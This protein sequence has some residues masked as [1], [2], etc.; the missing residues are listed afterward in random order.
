MPKSKY[1][2]QLDTSVEIPAVRDNITEIGSDVINSLRSA[3]IQ[4]E[5]TLGINPQGSVGNTLANRISAALD[6]QGNIKSEALEQANVLSGPIIDNDIA[7]SAAIQESKLDL[8]FPTQLLQDEIAV[9]SQQLDII[10]DSLIEISALLTA[11]LNTSALNRH[12]ATA[13]SVEAADTSPS[14]TASLSLEEGNLQTALETVYNA[15]INY[16]GINISELNNS[17]K[18]E[19]IFYDNSETLDTITQDDVQGAIDDLVNIQTVGL[20]NNSLNFH[21][22][23]RIRT[24]EVLDAYEGGLKGSILV[25]SSSITYSDLDGASKTTI[26]FTSNPTPIAEIR[27]FD[28]LT[29]AGSTKEDD[30]KEYLISEVNLD[31]DGKVDSIVIYGGPT[32]NSAADLFATVTKQTISSYNQNGLN[33]ATRPR[34][35]NTNTPYIQVANPNSATIISHGLDAINITSDVNK[36]GISIDGQSSVDISTFDNDVSEQTIDSVVNKINQQAVAKHYNF[37]AYKLRVNNCFEIALSH[38]VP[39]HADDIV[40]RTLKITIPT[41]DDGTIELGFSDLIDI[42][43]EGSRGNAYHI[44][45]LILQEFGIL[46]TFDSS[47]VSL[48][49][50][51]LDVVALTGSFI[52]AGIRV[53]DLLV[54]TGSSS[55]TDDGTYLISDISDT[56]L[57]LDDVEE[58]LAG[59]LG[60]DSN[61]QIIR[62][63]AP[64]GELTFTE[65]VGNTGSILFDVFI[66]DEQDVHFR[67]RIEIESALQGG[68]FVAAVVDVSS[69]FIIADETAE[70]TVGTD[71]LAF[72][73]GP[74]LLDGPSVDISTSGTYKLYAADGLSYVVLK[75]AAASPPTSEQSVVLNGFDEIGKTNYR[76]C[77][78]LFGTSLGIVFAESTDLGIPILID[79]RISGTTDDS[80]ISEPFIERYIEGPRNELRASGIIRGVEVNNLQKFTSPTTYFTCDISAGIAITNGIR[81]EM[82]GAIGFKFETTDDFYIVIDENGCIVAGDAVGSV[83]PFINQEVVHLAFIDAS[84]VELT[85]LRF[86][87]DKLDLKLLGDIIVSTTQNFGHFTSLKSAV[88]YARKFTDL[89]P[90]HGQPSIFIEEGD[91]DITETI[92]IDFD[93]AI[94]GAGPNTVLHR[95]GTIANGQLGSLGPSGNFELS[96]AL[97]IIGGSENSSSTSFINGVSFEDFSYQTSSTLT[98]PAVAFAITQEIDDLNTPNAMF[99]FSN[100]NL[101]GPA[102]LDQSLSTPIIEPG[103]VL[104]QSQAGVNAIPSG[105][106]MGNVIVTDCRFDYI[107][108]ETAINEPIL[109]ATCTVK[110]VI[111]TNNVVTNSSPVLSSTTVQ[112]FDTSGPFTVEN[113]LVFPNIGVYDAISESSSP[114]GDNPIATQGDLEEFSTRAKTHGFDVIRATSSTNIRVETGGTLEIGGSYY[115]LDEGSYI[116]ITTS[117]LFGTDVLSSSIWVY[118]YLKPGVSTAVPPVG[119]VSVTAPL[120]TGL[121]PSDSTHKFLTSALLDTNS[122]FLPF[123]KSGNRVTKVASGIGSV[124]ITSQITGSDETITPNMPGTAVGIIGK[125]RMVT[126]NTVTTGQSVSIRIG[127]YGSL[128]TTGEDLYATAPYSGSATRNLEFKFELP[129]DTNQEFLSNFDTSI[130]SSGTIR[131]AGYIEPRIR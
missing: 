43:F 58:S 111:V 96:Q 100:L 103:I 32:Q 41:D 2:E 85:D 125:Y 72:L 101:K 56:Q 128:A 9:V 102:T 122:Q 97:F 68:A 36:F 123:I 69:N 30:N 90:D 126:E 39:N 87:V 24:G 117:D 61:I 79:K 51:G 129:L 47:Q 89:F 114:S 12:P 124:T 53:G 131:V 108:T 119:V 76:T 27:E 8:D 105:L 22:N 54:I 28:I 7:K 14:D 82:S 6:E 23:G 77:R 55:S 110:N 18:A 130:Y 35:N 113:V 67:K 48:I 84:N 98:A 4:I 3:I 93:L 64:I 42:E 19:Q 52:D 94:R 16:S 26:T 57:V 92:L 13:I 65:I 21:S 20:R 45:G 46:K 70:I 50:S 95:A 115:V 116:D 106:T 80:I 73:T 62:A 49:Q 40:N 88:N 44:N 60:D 86:F 11:H 1:P 81:R 10:N 99:R 75:V 34:F 107:G 74:D 112:I 66:T 109:D 127:T 71:G 59:S 120:A 104:T 29:I 118:L 38:T 78:G 25:E 5:K 17:H 91:Y 31:G 37:L 121:H 15:H 33:C 83:S 63:T